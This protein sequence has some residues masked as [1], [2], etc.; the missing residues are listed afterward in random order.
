MRKKK[1][2]R[3]VCVLVALAPLEGLV[4]KKDE[5]FADP[6]DGSKEGAFAKST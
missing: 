2:G 4:G 3:G 1:V 6:D 5:N